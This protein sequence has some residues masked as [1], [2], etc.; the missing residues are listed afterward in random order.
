[1]AE[2]RFYDPL[3]VPEAGLTYS[4]VASIYR[5]KWLFVRHH[6]RTTWEMPG[7]HIEDTETS[8]EAAGRELMEE[9][10][11]TDFKLECV[12]TYSVNIDGITGYGRLYLA[13]VFNLGTIPDIS[14]IDEIKA[15]LFIPEENT[16]PEIQPLLFERILAHLK[17]KR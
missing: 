1:M 17:R 15:D 8:D 9:T 14:E 7:G 10:G 13:E 12:S 6:N 2:V 11:A 4:V 16:Y 5:G 3:F